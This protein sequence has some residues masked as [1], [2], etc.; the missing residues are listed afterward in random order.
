MASDGKT[1]SAAPSRS[2]PHDGQRVWLERVEE[3]YRFSIWWEDCYEYRL[4]PAPE[5]LA[6]ITRLQ[7]QG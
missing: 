3:R 6:E 2:A 7:E 4:P 5:T 1:D